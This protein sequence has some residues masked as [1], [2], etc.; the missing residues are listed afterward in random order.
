MGLGVTLAMGEMTPFFSYG[1]MSKK[2][3]ESKKNASES[4]MGLGLT[5]K[6][7]S[8]SVVVSYTTTTQK[9]DTDG[10]DTQ[11]ATATGIEL[12]YNTTVGAATLGVGYGSKSVSA[13]TGTWGDDGTARADG[14]NVTDIEVKMAFSF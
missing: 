6:M 3:K 9:A 12:G 14:Y 11:N 10:T 4:A 1:T 13:D 7:G 5:M 2:G 8:D